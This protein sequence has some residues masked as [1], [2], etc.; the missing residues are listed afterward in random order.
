MT[1]SADK[2]TRCLTLDALLL[3]CALLLSYVEYLLP[4]TRFFPLPGV[5]LGLA[6]LAVMFAFYRIGPWHA[7]AVSFC[8]IVISSV[9]FGSV[10]GFWFSLLGGLTAFGVLCLFS[11]PLFSGVWRI[12][13]SCACAAGHHLGQILAACLMTG[14]AGLISYLPV[15][16]LASI[17]LG[18]VTGSLLLLLESHLGD[19][20]PRKDIP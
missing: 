6:N 9:L 4:L 10:G 8:R 15:L 17:P 16:L 11:L 20:T 18:V 12:G 13:V 5:R 7:A 19:R 2:R 3:V 14:S 1:G